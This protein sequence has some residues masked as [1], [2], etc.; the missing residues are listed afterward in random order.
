MITCTNMYIHV[1][2]M[3]NV[4]ASIRCE[5]GFVTGAGVTATGVAIGSAIQRSGGD[6]NAEL[7][8]RDVKRQDLIFEGVQRPY[9][10]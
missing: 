3:Y 8:H 9:P 5:F 6:L 1:H 2:Y 4:L 7:R 10:V